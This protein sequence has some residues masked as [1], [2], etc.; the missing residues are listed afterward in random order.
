MKLLYV[1]SIDFYTKPNPSFHLMKSMLEDVLS[2][3]WQVEFIGC[4]EKG[5]DK[6]IPEEFLDNNS[7]S[8]SLVNVPHVKKSSFVQRY[9][10]GVK[11]SKKVGKL[12]K[13]KISVCD[14]VFV[15]S[16]PT[17]LYTLYYARKY[18]KQK[19]VI[20]NVQDMFPGSSIA[21]GVMPRKWMQTIFYSLQKIAYK[22]SDYITVISD[23][24]K[25]KV[26]EQGVDPEKIEVIVNWFDDRTV[27]EVDWSENRFVAKYKMSKNVFYIQYA[28]TMGYVFDYKVVLAVAEK[29][30]NNKSIVFQMIGDGS[31][32]DEFV[33]EA[34]RMNLDN[35]VF[36]PLEPQEMVSDVYSA[37]SLCF[38]P[39]KRGIIGNSVPS[40]AGLLM[41]CKRPIIT[42]ADGTS[43]YC[44][45]FAEN[46]MGIA[47]DPSDIDGLA[48][49]IAY[50]S[51]N[52]ELCRCYAQNGHEF[53]KE[54]YSRTYNMRKYFDLFDRC[55]AQK[56]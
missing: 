5:I 16:S 50:L 30:R 7:F 37:C 45:S 52:P 23:D 24:M 14:C 25:Q 36:L 48:D 12:I 10:E 38:I 34:K 18:A 3:G 51:Q 47:K 17:A 56:E 8:Y 40:K 32:K 46:E 28:G 2:A 26:I 53:G 43:F 22:K 13:D 41:A 15:Q 44:K 31:Q 6:H 20:Y 35:I 54:L 11:Y 19:K 21:S 39:L 33:Q 42:S 55:Q 1:A 4:K 27:H 49:A 9:I 29:L